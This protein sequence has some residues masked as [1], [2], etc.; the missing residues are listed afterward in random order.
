MG[1]MLGYRETLPFSWRLADG[2]LPTGWA[3]Q[4]LRMLTALVALGERAI[5]E[6]ETPGAAEFERLHLKVDLV[7]ELLAALLRA[8]GRADAPAALRV[9]ADGLSWPLA[10][11][12]PAIGTAVDV[13]VQLHPCAPAPLQWRG[14]VIGHDDG[15]LQLRFAPMPEALACALERHV[16]MQHRR[17]VAGAR[18]PA[19]RGD[20]GPASP[21][22]GTTT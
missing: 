8:S 1:A 15:E 12:A 5:V 16:F 10:T 20:A 21:K 13:G 6:P 3:E 2:A 18:S 9:S 19:Q 22:I 11:G 7:I 17:S 4:N 14:E